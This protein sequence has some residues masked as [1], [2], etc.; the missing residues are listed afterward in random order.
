MILHEISEKLEDDEKF[1]L[2]KYEHDKYSLWFQIKKYGEN[3]IYLN[4]HVIKMGSFL[5]DD[6]AVTRILAKVEEL[7]KKVRNEYKK[8][9]EL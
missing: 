1:I 9:E 5:H 4:G 7:L 2:R 3:N 6:V 8:G